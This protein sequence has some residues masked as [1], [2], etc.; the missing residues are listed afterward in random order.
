MRYEYLEFMCCPCCKGKLQIEASKKRDGKIESGS[1]ACI[2]SS[3]GKIYSV[4]NFIPRF[5]EDGIYAQS[6]GEQWKTFART[7]LDNTTYQETEKRWNS[8]VGWGEVDIAGMRLIEFGSGAGR[9]VD[10]VS[11]KGAK[12]I[13][14]V[15]ITDAVDAAQ[16]NLGER[17][18]VFFVQADFFNP[19]FIQGV[20][21]RGYSIGVLHHTP[22]P[23]FAFSTLVELLNKNAKVGISLYE[24]SLYRRPNKNSFK[25]STIELLWALNLWRVEMFR[26]VTTRVPN[27]WMLSYCKYFVPF[28]HYINKIPVI[29][30]IRYFF[31]S[32]CYRNLPVEWSM[33][34]TNDTYATKI[35]H[36]YR[37]KDIFQWFM[38]KNVQDII[39]HNSIAGW[40][41]LTGSM[42][43]ADNLCYEKYLHEQPFVN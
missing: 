39:V 28:L 6:F 42:K 16:D 38:R 15:D 31:P 18:N 29:R 24:I 13:V 14:G 37:H 36:Q 3:C 23:E 10:I 7:Q 21:D 41:S 4:I 30:Y 43:R 5:V 11:K 19:P 25:V 12:L 22:A 9:F 17:N 1:I 34:D 40:V 27:S 35:V 20:F 8:E 26:V 32:T 33:L 2:N